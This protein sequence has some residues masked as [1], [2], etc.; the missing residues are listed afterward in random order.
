MLRSQLG[1]GDGA[2]ALGETAGDAAGEAEGPGELAAA[3]WT[4]TQ[5]ILSP[6]CSFSATSSP[7]LTSPKMLNTDGWGASTEVLSV[8]LTKNWLPLTA[9]LRAIATVPTL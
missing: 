8:V 6:F 5:Y 7:E 9:V 2:A 3:T 1:D 4:A